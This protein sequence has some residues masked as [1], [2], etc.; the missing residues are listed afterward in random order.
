MTR[1]EFEEKT[2]EW[3]NEADQWYAA[4]GIELHEYMGISWEEYCKY[5]EGRGF[6][7]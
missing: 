7:E 1:E 3:H 4:H 5:V 6:D 2:E